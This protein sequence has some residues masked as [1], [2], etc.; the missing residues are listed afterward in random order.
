MAKPA[1]TRTSARQPQQQLE[2]ST[3]R[4]F[5]GGLNVVDTELNMTPRFARVLKN[6]ER[7]LDGSLSVRPGTVF[8]A[9]VN[10]WGNSNDIING[11]YFNNHA[12]CVQANGAITKTD[13]SGTT[14]QMLL[15]GVNPWTTAITRAHF[16]VFNND[17]TIWNGVDKPLIIPGNPTDPNYMTLQFLVDKASLSNINTPRGLYAATQGRYLVVAGVPDYPSTIFVTNQDTSGTFPGDPAPNDAIQLDIGSRV[18]IGSSAITGLVAYRDKLLVTFERGVLPLTLGNYTGSPAVH[19]PTDDGFIEEY[20][21]VSHRTLVSVSDDAFFCD[22]IGVN[23]IRRIALFS[24]LRPE[25]A[26]QYIDPLFTA[27]MQAL[28]TAQVEELVHAVYDLRNRRYLIFVPVISGGVVTETVCF[29]YTSIPSLSISAWAELRGWNWRC[30]FRST[31]QNIFFARGTKLYYYDFDG[32]DRCA[33]RLNDPAVNSGAGEAISFDWELPW[34]DFQ[35]RMHVKQSHYLGL[36]TQ[37][38][39]TFTCEMYVDNF[40]TRQG[41]DTPYLSLKFVAG[42]AGGFGNVPYGNSPFGGGRD[43]SEERLFAWPSRFK[44]MK[45]RF[46][47]TTTK[48]IKF[49]SI[50]I[51][52]TRGSIRR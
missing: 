41:S 7:S 23:V 52:Y 2:T 4:T 34:A 39:G 28:T 10:Q 36:D 19:T 29:S 21:C 17:L 25:R 16:A 33:D 48:P 8:F 3:V 15:G 47:G 37:G 45:L 38:I 35:R 12:I 49:V 20:G 1:S 14:T 40:R 31:L 26:S 27:L 51:A 50:T 18:S 9:D 43:S 13:A 22:N 24:T 46:K 11:I 30:A 42:D 32:E 5:D 44:L 6:L